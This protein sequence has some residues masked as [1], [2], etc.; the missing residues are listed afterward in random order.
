MEPADGY[1]A[2]TDLEEILNRALTPL[3]A[4]LDAMEARLGSI[5]AK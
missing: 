4:R 5:E 1:I 3:S 2:K